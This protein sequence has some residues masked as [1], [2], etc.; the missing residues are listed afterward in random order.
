MFVG[1]DAISHLDFFDTYY[2]YRTMAPCNKVHVNSIGSSP[3]EI[4][5][6][7][8]IAKGISVQFHRCELSNVPQDYPVHNRAY[9]SWSIA[10]KY[11]HMARG[12]S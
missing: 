2:C 11:R 7:C 10:S 3:S 12:S 4:S 8:T 1:S 5:S 6:H 9:L